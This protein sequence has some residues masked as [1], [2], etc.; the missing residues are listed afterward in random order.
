MSFSGLLLLLGL[1]GVTAS[2]STAV[3]LR[4][5]LRNTSERVLAALVLGH[6]FVLVPV[7]ALGTLSAL[8]SA[9]SALG[10]LAVNAV[11]LAVAARGRSMAQAVAEVARAWRQLLVDFARFIAPAPGHLPARAVL[12]C[13]VAGL[14]VWLTLTCYFA[15]SFRAYDAPWYHEPITAFAIQERGLHVPMLP[16]RLL[17]VASFTRG[18]ELVSAWLVLITGSRALIELPSIVAFAALWLGTYRL[19]RVLGACQSRALGW[20]TVVVLTPGLLAYAQSTYV[21]LHACAMLT[22][23][24]CFALARPASAGALLALVAACLA[25]SM[26]LYALGPGAFLIGIALLRLL[27]AEGWSALRSGAAALVVLAAAGVALATPLRNAVVFGNPL[28][29]VQVTLPFVQRV[30]PG[31]IAAT[32]LYLEVITSWEELLR[33]VFQ[34]LAAYQTSFTHYVEVHLPIELAPAFNHGY[35]MPTLGLGLAVVALGRFAWDAVRAKTSGAGRT[36]SS[37]TRLSLARLASAAVMVVAVAAFF[38]VFPVTRLA[39]YLGF[40]FACTGALAATALVHRRV[41]PVGDALLVV[42]V[43]VQLLLVITQSPKLLYSPAEIWRLAHMPAS[44]RE[45]APL[46][47]A[48][49]SSDAARFRDQALA[50]GTIVFFG[51]DVLEPGPLWNSSISNRVEYLP[52]DGDPTEAADRRGATLVACTRGS[53]RCTAIEARSDA[54]TLVGELYPEIISQECLVFRRRA[55]NHTEFDIA[56]LDVHLGSE[57]SYPLAREFA[58]RRKN[59]HFVGAYHCCVV[60]HASEIEA[61]MRRPRSPRGYD[62]ALSRPFA[63]DEKVACALGKRRAQNKRMNK[64]APVVQLCAIA[65]T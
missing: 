60:T 53:R 33:L 20:A 65:A 18:S 35:A 26:K 42:A 59:A 37:R 58:L 9:S 2:A 4:F 21:D 6:L 50:K 40:V 22:A 45:L 14:T 43:F 7:Y 52:G 38:L 39:R 1:L 8:S 41:R 25:L 32:S 63:L 10:T 57:T 12:V 28:Y 34:P 15:P 5:R 11:A 48:F 44:D 56:L 55:A 29:P 30:L 61:R 3:T 54:W 47:G 24:A 19:G 17:Y 36:Q 64:D 13:G 49:A 27:R 46:Y 23:A 16:E 31:P 51:D 62:A